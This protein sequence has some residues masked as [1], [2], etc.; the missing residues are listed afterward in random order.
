M[1]LNSFILQSTCANYYCNSPVRDGDDDEISALDM[2][3]AN[4]SVVLT[5]FEDQ[6]KFEFKKAL[7][8]K[9]ETYPHLMAGN[10]VLTNFYTASESSSIGTLKAVNNSI[11]NVSQAELNLFTNI[12][13][14][15][16]LINGILSNLQQLSTTLQNA[17]TVTAIAKQQYWDTCATLHNAILNSATDVAQYDDMQSQKKL[18]AK[19][20]NEQVTCTDIFDNNIKAVNE[21]YLS[22][23]LASAFTQEEK[24]LLYSIAYQ[25]P[26]SG[27]VGVFQA[28]VLVSLYDDNVEYDDNTTCELDGYAMRQTSNAQTQ[29]K[30]S[31]SV[32]PNPSKNYFD[33]S[34]TGIVLKNSTLFLYDAF[35]NVVHKVVLMN[36]GI[37]RVDISTIASGVYQI[38]LL[39][40]FE[41]NYSRLVIV[42]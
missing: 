4:N 27:G 9:L 41:R 17:T 20:Q 21:I 32:L 40:G 14:K 30:I 2:Q 6:T 19:A 42:K 3:I 37:N 35:G 8:T 22:G 39:N 24:D 16:D 34:A 13:A 7:N 36:D 23:K 31:F 26:F 1:F 33:I 28:R 29:E 10:S 38:C 5:E 11:S 15:Q 12:G 18:I 25:C